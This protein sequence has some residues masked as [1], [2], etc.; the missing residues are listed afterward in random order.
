[1]SR[2]KPSRGIDARSL[3]AS[4][5][6]RFTITRTAGTDSQ[7]RIPQR[8]TSRGGAFTRGQR[9][10]RGGLRGRGNRGARRGSRGSRGNRSAA[11]EPTEEEA[12][13]ELPELTP[14]EMKRMDMVHG[15]FP[16]P[17]EP[18]TTLESLITPVISSPRGLVANVKY[19]MEV[20]TSNTNGVHK[21]GGEHLA[22]M[23]R[24]EGT[25]FESAEAKT[26][27]ED[28]NNQIRKERAERF[29]W[30][31]TPEKLRTLSESEREVLAKR[32]AAGQY[33]LPRPTASNDILGQVAS[34][35]RRNE[36]YLVEDGQKLEAKLRSLLPAQYQ[37]ADSEKPVPKVN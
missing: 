23:E 11:R 7:V 21:I 32:W 1:M 29:G 13:E 37:K 28:F 25:F 22:R 15:G 24:G 31:Y 14:A 36:T 26:I 2:N 5:P 10:V 3:A 8:S 35:S 12:D 19:K 30:D 33:E 16:T 6:P 4:P 18:T 34:Y 9:G 20:A 17:Y 27:V